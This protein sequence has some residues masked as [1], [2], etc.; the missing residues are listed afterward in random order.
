MEYQ[1]PEIPN[2]C[3]VEI[4]SNLLSPETN[5]TENLLEILVPRLT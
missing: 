5:L 3:N 2:S 4:V 1:Y